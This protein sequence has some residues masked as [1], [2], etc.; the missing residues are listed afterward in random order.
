MTATPRRTGIV[1]MALATVLLSVVW[2][3]VPLQSPPIYD[4]LC[5]PV[6]HYHYFEPPAGI[7]VNEK[8]HPAAKDVPFDKGVQP[9]TILLT[10][11]AAGDAST[12]PQAELI[13]GE[14][15]VA[16]PAGTTS[17]HLSITAV[18]APKV[19][20]TDGTIDGNVYHFAVT[21]GG[22]ELALKDLVTVSLQLT[23]VPSSPKRVVEQFVDGTW[24]PLETEAIAC[25]LWATSA[26]TLGDFALVVPGTPAKPP[27]TPPA[28]DD[29]N[30]LGI[31]LAV[32]AVVVLGGAALVMRRFQTR[33]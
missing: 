9:V 21:A 3:T 17:I 7:T 24:V 8:P 5:T 1:A 11:E 33:A 23:P 10:D 18:P 19:G 6:P 31:I 14:N 20:P 15:S 12:Q 2:L 4:G 22:K 32:V 28:P 30:A 27:V 29:S 26:K 13:L 25:V 16:Y